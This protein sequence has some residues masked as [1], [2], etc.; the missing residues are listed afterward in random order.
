MVLLFPVSEAIE[1]INYVKMPNKNTQIYLNL[2]K[3]WH[4]C[5]DNESTKIIGI[6][7]WISVSKIASNIQI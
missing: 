6:L 4:L 1:P 5:E 3:R 7:R 2:L